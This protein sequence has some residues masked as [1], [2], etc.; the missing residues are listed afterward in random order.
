MNPEK[1]V[2]QLV[3]MLSTS[4]I[5]LMTALAV[6]FMSIKSFKYY[7]PILLGALFFV[8]VGEAINI[9]QMLFNSQ[10]II[11]GQFIMSLGL[12][13]LCLFFLARHS[14]GALMLKMG[15]S[16]YRELCERRTIPEEEALIKPEAPKN[17]NKYEVE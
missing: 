2:I 3:I 7:H 9:W 13:A 12:A 10:A 14:T 8:V 11:R 17:F 1:D 6:I 16:S 4:G 15:F 5:V